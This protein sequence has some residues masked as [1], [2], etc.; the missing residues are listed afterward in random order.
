LFEKSETF[1][2]LPISGHLPRQKSS[3]GDSLSFGFRLET[4][5]PEQK[6]GHFSGL[7]TDSSGFELCL[8]ALPALIPTACIT[9]CRLRKGTGG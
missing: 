4:A 9:S 3:T 1:I 2:F 7:K 6:Y 5:R 8:S